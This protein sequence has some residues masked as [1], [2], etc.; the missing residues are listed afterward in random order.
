M[1]RQTLNL[2]GDKA[3]ARK[4]QRMAEASYRRVMRPAIRAGLAPM[5]RAIRPLAPQDTGLL[6]VAISPKMS[7]R[8]AS[9]RVWVDP[10]MYVEIDGRTRRASKYAHLV[11]FGTRHLAA[12]P[13]MRPGAAAARGPALARVESVAAREL[14]KEARR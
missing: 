14:A 5:V 3:L 7:R 9:G 13:F 10:A 4:L 2:L 11:E 6:A 8:A 12:R 1:A